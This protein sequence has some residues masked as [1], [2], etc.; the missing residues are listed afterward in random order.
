[1][2]TGGALHGVRV[3]DLSR[4]LA[5]P[6][7]A[8]MLA[9]HGAEVIKVEFPAG[10]ETRRWGPPFVDEAESMS[11]YYQGLN[12]SKANIGLDLR[13]ERAREVLHELIARADV[14]VE[15]FKAGTLNR[16]GLG[17]ESRLSQ[18]FPRLVHCRITGYGVD[19]PLGGLP[20]YDAVLQA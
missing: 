20:G 15:N 8:Q 18:E 17:Y 9:D 10:D 14:V 3:L 2:S 7:C 4:V 1:M 13:V 12:R 5:G 16:W 6:L 11:A 19:G